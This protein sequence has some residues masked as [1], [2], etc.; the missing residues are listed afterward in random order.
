M[1]G[2]GGVFLLVHGGCKADL[3]NWKRTRTD[4]PNSNGEFTGQESG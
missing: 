2:G 4:C 3:G 1:G